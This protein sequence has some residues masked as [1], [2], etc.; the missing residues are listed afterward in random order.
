[1]R[2][3]PDPQE[4]AEV[5]HKDLQFPMLS[6]TPALVVVDGLDEAVD[7]RGNGWVVLI[8]VEDLGDPFLDD[9]TLGTSRGGAISRESFTNRVT[10]PGVDAHTSDLGHTFP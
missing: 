10:E 7:G 3:E 6:I 5:L 8:A 4:A 9:G 1:M 2:R